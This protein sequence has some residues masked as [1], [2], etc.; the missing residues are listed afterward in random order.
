MGE[1][2]FVAQN[3]SLKCSWGINQSACACEQQQR[4]CRLIYSDTYLPTASSNYFKEEKLWSEHVRE[5]GSSAAGINGPARSLPPGHE[6]EH[7][8]NFFTRRELSEPVIRNL[9]VLFWWLPV[10]LHTSNTSRQSPRQSVQE[11]T[12]LMRRRFSSYD[13]G[14]STSGALLRQPVS[15]NFQ[16]ISYNYDFKLDFKLWCVK[17][18][19]TESQYRICEFFLP[20][21]HLLQIST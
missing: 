17:I 5:A 13:N 9:N 20:L 2:W 3:R 8:R 11:A 7:G 4:T 21:A 18:E 16:I 10:F 14:I 19:N 1:G 6:T 15:K 12:V